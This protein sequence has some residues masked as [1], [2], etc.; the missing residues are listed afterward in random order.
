MQHFIPLNLQELAVQ[1]LH[2][3]LQKETLLVWVV[4]VLVCISEKE[5]WSTDCFVEGCVERIS[6][7]RDY[8]GGWTQT[9]R[10]QSTS[11][12]VWYEKQSSN[13]TPKKLC[14][15]KPIHYTFWNLSKPYVLH[16]SACRNRFCSASSFFLCLIAMYLKNQRFRLGFCLV[17]KGFV[18]GFAILEVA[19]SGTSSLGEAISSM[20]QL[21]SCRWTPRCAFALGP[22]Q[23]FFGRG[24][25]RH[26]CFWKSFRTILGFCMCFV[27]LCIFLYVFGMFACSFL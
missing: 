21:S 4:S 11:E 10:L 23:G 8:F 25:K 2:R 20:A 12:C 7:C 9:S 17:C 14:F 5:G 13:I 16:H 1:L 22:R 27:Y 18:P 24:G 26:V 15:I 3:N 6:Y 19:I